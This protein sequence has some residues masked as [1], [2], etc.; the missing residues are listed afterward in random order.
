MI[1]SENIST[2]TKEELAIQQARSE[3]ETLLRQYSNNHEFRTI[4]IA[5]IASPRKLLWMDVVI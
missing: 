2:S 1:K 5:I 3:A 4:K